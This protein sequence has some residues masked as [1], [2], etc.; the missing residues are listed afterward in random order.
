MNRTVFVGWGVLTMVLAAGC[1]GGADE[2]VIK[3]QINLMNEL[4]A[5]YEKVSDAASLAKAQADIEKLQT[6]A[7]ELKR[8]EGSWSEEK[9]QQLGRQYESELNA[10]TERLVKSRAEARKKSGGKG[11]EP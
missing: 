10:A 8:K 4:A 6:R 1:G 5:S 7:E 2:A 9:K 3:D 11:E